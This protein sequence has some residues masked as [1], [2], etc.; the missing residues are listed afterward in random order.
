[1]R[2]LIVFLA[3]LLCY[4]QYAFWFGH[5]GYLDNQAAEENVAQLKEE[6]Q[7]LEARNSRIQAEIHD[8]KHGVNALEERART[9]FEMVKPNEQFYRIIPKN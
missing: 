1:M 8:L 3:F 5:N 7:V 6:H 4:C 2:L 9:R